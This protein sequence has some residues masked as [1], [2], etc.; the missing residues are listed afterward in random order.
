MHSEFHNTHGIGRE[1]ELRACHSLTALQLLVGGTALETLGL[2]LCGDSDALGL[3]LQLYGQG[4]D[5]FQISLPRLRVLHH[6]GTH[7]VGQFGIRQLYS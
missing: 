7:T 6:A 3:Q 2:G 5:Q 4:I 1:A